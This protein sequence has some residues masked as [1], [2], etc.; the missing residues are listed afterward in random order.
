MGFN[1][2]KRELVEGDVLQI[3]P[4]HERFGGFLLVCTEPKPWGCQGYL[5]SAY[6]FKAVKFKGIAYL[7][8]KF[9]DM[10]YVGRMEW[11]HVDKE[12]DI[13]HT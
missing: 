5:M 4:D 3:H 2:E 8:V 12:E 9:E 7:R 6:D 1:M 13:S 11:L 10:E